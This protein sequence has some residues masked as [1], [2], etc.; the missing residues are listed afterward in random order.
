MGNT[1]STHQP[2]HQ[3]IRRKYNTRKKK[4]SISEYSPYE[5]MA[6]KKDCSL[7]D[8]KKK[9]KELAAIY[10]PDNGG[11]KRIFMGIVQSYKE[12]LFEKESNVDNKIKAPVINKE[13]NPQNKNST[14]HENVHIDKDNFNNDK[15]N[16]IFRDYRI[17]NPY[18]EGYGKTMTESEKNHNSR[19]SINIERL[20]S[21]NKG[22]FNENFN[23]KKSTTIIEYEEPQALYSNEQNNVME[24]G[25]KKINDFSGDSYTDYKR[26]YNNEFFNPNNVQYKTYKSV[27]EYENARS[28]KQE[29][30]REEVEYHSMIKRKKEQDEIERRKNQ[31]EYDQI[32]EDQFNNLNKVFIKN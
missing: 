26:A 19:E 9:Y 7:K 30:T 22:N 29:M 28:Q 1:E 17:E 31:K 3:P 21:L 14:N 10:H 5:I 15:F 13:Y 32:Y 2:T 4:E 11:N 18:D 23:E 27:G 6:L 16:K 24:L 20:T 12:I 25:V 8:L